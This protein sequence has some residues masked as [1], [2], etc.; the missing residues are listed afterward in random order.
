MGKWYTVKVDGAPIEG[1][2]DDW[3]EAV[4]WMQEANGPDRFDGEAY[5]SIT[6]KAV[7]W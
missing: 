3:D 4:R 2:T 6:R 7:A 1:S 5:I